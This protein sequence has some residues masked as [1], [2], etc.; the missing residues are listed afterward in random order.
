MERKSTLERHTSGGVL[1][2]KRGALHASIIEELL[3]AAAEGQPRAAVL[4]AGGPAAGKSWLAERLGPG[5]EDGFVLINPDVVR[6]SLPEYQE[7]LEA[8]DPEAAALTH[9]EASL[10]AKTATD[11]AI[12]LGLPLLIDAVGGDDHGQFSSKIR[13]LLDHGYDI[14]VRYVSVPLDV[15]GRREVDRA[16]ATGRAVPPEVLVS[17]HSEVSRGFTN[18]ARIPG[19]RL[20]I[21]DNTGNE[22]ILMAEGFGDPD[23]G[24]EALTVH[25]HDGYHLFLEKAHL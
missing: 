24:A 12:S 19:V 10:V 16:A 21:Y 15:A 20:E 13:R 17:K 5:A 9:E 14:T 22:P 18:V 7:M 25:D 4:Y 6:T 3:R 2:A 23:L 1:S 8:G 11:V